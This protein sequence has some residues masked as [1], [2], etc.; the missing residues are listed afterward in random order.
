MKALSTNRVLVN[1]LLAG[2]LVWVYGVGA[3]PTILVVMG[4]ILGLE[5]ALFAF[6]RFK[7]I[8]YRGE[9]GGVRDD[10]SF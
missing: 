7:G 6:L 8:D 3:L 10:S 9:V 2:V 5:W 4:V 1:T